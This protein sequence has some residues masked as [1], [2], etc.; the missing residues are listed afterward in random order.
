MWS[1]VRGIEIEVEKSTHRYLAEYKYLPAT[2]GS[3]YTKHGDPGYPDES[4]EVDLLSVKIAGH[5]I[6]PVMAED[7]VDEIID[8]IY[9][10][11][12]ERCDR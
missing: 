5:D 1:E 7:V 3:M 12:G 9:R 4:A 10:A 2:R 11:E 6:L 8:E